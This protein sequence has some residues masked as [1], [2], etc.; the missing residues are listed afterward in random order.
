MHVAVHIRCCTCSDSLDG[1]KH[2]AAHRKL[3]QKFKQLQQHAQQAQ[4]EHAQ[5]AQAQH[6]QHDQDEQLCDRLK[7]EVA[8]RTQ[9]GTET[10]ARLA[11]AV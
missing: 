8:A 10:Q 2:Q 11:L 9:Q 7:R 4:H 6:A 5:E 1:S 3:L